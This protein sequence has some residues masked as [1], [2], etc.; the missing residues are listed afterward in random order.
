MVGC[1]GRIRGTAGMVVLDEET[2]PASKLYPHILNW[3][4]AREG[5]GRWATPISC[6]LLTRPLPRRLLSVDLDWQ[7]AAALNVPPPACRCH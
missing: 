2:R 4:F 1:R 6:R 5:P 3:E 7:E